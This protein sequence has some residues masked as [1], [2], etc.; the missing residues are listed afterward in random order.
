MQWCEFGQSIN[1]SEDFVVDPDRSLKLLT[2]M[3]HSVSDGLDAKGPSFLPA[4][5]L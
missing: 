5:L 4:R 3:D 1:R 2:S